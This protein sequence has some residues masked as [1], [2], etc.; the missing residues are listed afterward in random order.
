MLLVP[1]KSD[2]V[3]LLSPAANEPASS[4]WRSALT[5]PVGAPKG[6]AAVCGAADVSAAAAAALTA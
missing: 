3:S 1:S 4:C 5:L 2:I 6:N